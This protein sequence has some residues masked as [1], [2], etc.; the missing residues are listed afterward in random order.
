M[1]AKI[2]RAPESGPWAPGY[3]SIL[4]EDGIR[5]EANYV[6]GAGNLAVIKDKPLTPQQW[7]RP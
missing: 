3:Y 4:F 6:P 5:L 1:G 7:D 2:V